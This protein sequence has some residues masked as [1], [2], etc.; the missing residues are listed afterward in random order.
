L[1]LVEQCGHQTGAGLSFIDA[2]GAF[3][4]RTKAEAGTKPA[5][6]TRGRQ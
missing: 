6:R 1:C 5:G 3:I 4:E 2:G